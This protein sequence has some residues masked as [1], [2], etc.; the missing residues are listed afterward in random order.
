[1]KKLHIIGSG[2]G[3]KELLTLKAYEIL[4]KSDIILY[5]N[6][7]SDEILAITPKSC[8]K[9]YVG[10]LPYK[11]SFSQDEIN[12]LIKAYFQQY[13]TIVRLKSGDPYIFGRGFEEWLWAKEQNI[14][15]EYTPG[16]SSMHGAGLNDIPL[17]HRGV[18]EG[19]WILTGTKQDGKM[20]ADLTHAAQSNATVVIY[21]GMNKLPEI[22]R[23]YV[24]QNKGH[25]PAAIIQNIGRPQ[26]KKVICTVKDLVWAS[27]EHQMSHPAIII[28]GSVVT[29]QFGSH[30]QFMNE[31]HII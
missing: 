23:T 24:L 7:I 28:I 20:T 8:K 15:I 29:L 5:D 6:L 31:R 14:N 12:N 25:I 18:S 27:K 1:M 19:I 2:T 10:K 3:Q 4:K 9:V 16:I 22:T 30:Q 17:T 11:K 13:S 26:Q 21:M